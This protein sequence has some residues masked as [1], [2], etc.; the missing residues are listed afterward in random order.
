[1][2]TDWEDYAEHILEVMQ[3]S[4]RFRN[5]AVAG[6]TLPRPDYRPVTKFELRGQRLG[7]G[8]WDM[9]FERI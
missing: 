6:K 4:P 3:Q 2:A 9:M 7:H 1:M 5:C 8:V